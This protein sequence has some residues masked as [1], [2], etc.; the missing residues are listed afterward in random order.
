MI[1]IFN[2]ISGQLV[3]KGKGQELR[4]DYIT[5]TDGSEFGEVLLNIVCSTDPVYKDSFVSA[6]L[7]NNESL[8]LARL[9]VEQV[10]EDERKFRL[11]QQESK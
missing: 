10:R 1:K 8:I 5:V 3:K 11:S 7:S 4:F 2:D 9:L 6:T